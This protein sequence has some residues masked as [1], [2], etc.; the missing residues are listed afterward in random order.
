VF[1]YSDEDGTEAERLS[2]KVDPDEVLS[3]AAAVQD[4]VDELV[5]QRAE[6]RIGE[7][8]E[9]LVETVGADGVEGRAVH[10][11]PDVDGSTRVLDADHA[12]IGDTVL[13]TVVSS[14]GVDLVATAA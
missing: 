8:V 9:V 10:Q 6:D 1:G 5:S 12:R 2:D 11:G 14:D 4:L 13:A 7:S 3:R